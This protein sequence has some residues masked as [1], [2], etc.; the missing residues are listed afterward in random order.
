MSPFVFI[1]FST[2][3]GIFGQLLLK[4]GMNRIGQRPGAA[5][6]LAIIKS[7]WVIGGLVVYGTGVIFWLLALSYFEIS[8]VYPFASLSYIGII[9]GSYFIFKERLSV[10]R[11]MGIA[12]IIAGVLII[13]QT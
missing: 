5:F 12:M 1:A 3:F 9:F 6:L 13:S 2:V 4:S 7:P 10:A 8:Y 11:L